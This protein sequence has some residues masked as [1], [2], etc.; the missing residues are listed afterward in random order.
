MKSHLTILLISILLIVSSCD[1]VLIFDGA[2][3]KASKET[4]T[5]FLK[6]K[7]KMIG[8]YQLK[9]EDNNFQNECFD[10]N[11]FKLYKKPNLKKT[12][13][14]TLYYFGSA[15]YS[16]RFL[17][18]SS[19]NDNLH[20]EHFSVLNKKIY[21]E[22]FHNKSR[23][24]K[25][26]NTDS[27][28]VKTEL[29]KDSLIFVVKYLNIKNVAENEKKHNNDTTFKFKYWEISDLLCIQNNINKNILFFFN[30]I[31]KLNNY[32]SIYKNNIY[33]I[34]KDSASKKTNYTI[35]RLILNKDGFSINGFYENDI[36]DSLFKKLNIEY[37]DTLVHYKNNVLDK[38]IN[39]ELEVKQI[40]AIKIK[41]F[42]LFIRPKTINW[43]AIIL[44]S[45]GCI[46]VLII[47]IKKIKCSVRSAK[48]I[49]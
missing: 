40:D 1:V 26:D 7:D 49:S 27:V 30:N 24:V 13:F 21:N 20:F 4:I 48:I 28:V 18:I 39:T 9:T 47:I 35:N 36:Q 17:E 37:A 22:F 16:N 34:N 2:P 46:L 32:I 3:Q 41:N 29:T 14:D 11:D 44:I 8:I 31:F 6:D 38:L 33:I 25:V 43:Y 12:T 42:P 45:L 15:F 5:K 19:V 23:R 10:K